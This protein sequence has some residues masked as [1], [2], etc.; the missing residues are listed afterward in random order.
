[1]PC[2][3]ACCHIIFVFLFL[4]LFDT[5]GTLIGV[6]QEGGLLR[7]DGT[8]PRVRQALVADAA[9]SC[10]GADP[11]RLLL[12][13]DVRRID[14]DDFSEAIPAF[15]TLPIMALTFSITE[16][17]AFGFI[18]YALLKTVRGQLREVSLL[19]PGFSILFLVRYV[20]LF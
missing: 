4:D 8:L 15:L 16:G 9:G 11:C 5:V 20:F 7:E 12:V 6:S 19:V 18:S 14:W 3:L 10:A 17:I 13:E 1:M 2:N